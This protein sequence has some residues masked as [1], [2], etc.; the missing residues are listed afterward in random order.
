MSVTTRHFGTTKHGEA[1][2]AYTITNSNKLSVTVLTLG[3]IVQSVQ[4]PD[5]DGQL[6]EVVL[7]CNTVEDYENNGCY[8]G[9]IIGRF[10]NR[11]AEGRFTLNQKNYTLA[12]NNGPNHL[13]GGLVGLDK[14]VWQAQQL[15]DGIRLTTQLQDG[16]EGYPGNVDVTVDYRLSEDNALR[17]DY[18]ASTDAPTVI[19]LTN[20]S[21]FNLAGSGDCLSHQLQL[22][23][24]YFTPT[25]ANAIPTGDITPVH[26]TPMD[27]TTAKAIGAH[28]DADHEQLRFGN[29]YDHNYVLWTNRAQQALT[30]FARVEE[31]ST[32]RVM[33]VETTTPGVQLYTGNYLTNQ[34]SRD[35]TLL[36]REGFCLE[37]QYF[38]DSPNQP[39]F[40]SGT[41]NPDKSYQ[42]STVFRFSVS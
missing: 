40:P 7:G 8:L 35:A 23:C 28:I 26:G 11:I 6:G 36:F 2:Q 12:V 10:A 3:G 24:E 21:Y 19:N 4:V 15:D 5:C 41:V 37:T 33:T 17:I 16:E 34:P 38:P 20:H 13:H 1:V 27:F 29:G 9:A 39:S 14:K 32:G 25:D 30:L 31:P 42:E 18:H 22:S